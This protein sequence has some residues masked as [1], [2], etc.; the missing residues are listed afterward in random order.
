MWE[1]VEFSFKGIDLPEVKW[2]DTPM[3]YLYGSAGS[4]KTTFLKAWCALSGARY[5]SALD[6][7]EY[8]RGNCK[9]AQDVYRHLNRLYDE[10]RV[11]I[12]DLANEPPQNFKLYG[13][14]F[15]P[16]EIFRT[17]LFKRCDETKRTIIASNLGLVKLSDMY[18]ET[19]TPEGK[20]P[21]GRINSRLHDY[22]TTYF[23]KGDRRKKETFEFSERMVGSKKS[24]IPI[25]PDPEAPEKEKEV[26]KAE[27]EAV[28]GYV[29]K[30]EWMEPFFIQWLK[31]LVGKHEWAKEMLAK[32]EK[33]TK[34]KGAK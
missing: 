10:P 5:I 27:A 22:A 12:D 30:Q 32:Y 9:D 17:A 11:A 23:F 21:R 29:E 24:T 19:E 33:T 20:M 7:I 14:E 18:D 26:T 4:G 13:T 8:L 31:T 25:V 1:K 15:S 34:K 6:F 16:R 2:L 28:A 3:L